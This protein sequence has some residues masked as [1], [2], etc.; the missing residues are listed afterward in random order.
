MSWGWLFPGRKRS[1]KL[2]LLR[3]QRQIL[4]QGMETTAEVLDS[5]VYGDKVGNLLPVSLWI[6][7]KKTDGTYS[8][9]HSKTLV[10][11]RRIP[12]KGQLLR[13]KYYPDN[14]ESVVII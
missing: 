6:K 9:T 3:E 7:L 1:E 2:R 5:T 14:T 4:H 8:F 12:A 10:S 11:L 13:I